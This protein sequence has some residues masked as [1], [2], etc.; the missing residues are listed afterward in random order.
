MILG[1]ALIESLVLLAFVIAFF[2]QGFA[3]QQALAAQHAA[4]QVA[5]DVNEPDDRA[6]TTSRPVP[7]GSCFAVA[8]EHDTTDD[9]G[10]DDEPREEPPPEPVG[11]RGKARDPRCEATRRPRRRSSSTS[12]TCIGMS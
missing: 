5:A 7:R 12:R 9:E 1:L 3:D 2:L 10:H 11:G 4:A 8:H 6:A